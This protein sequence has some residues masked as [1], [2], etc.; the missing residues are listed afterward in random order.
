MTIGNWQ[1]ATRAG[2]TDWDA[3]YGITIDNAGNCY[4]TGYF[5]GTATFGFYSLT[6]SG[7]NDIF[8]AKLDAIGNWLWAARAGGNHWD[9]GKAISID[10]AGNSYVIGEFNGYSNIWFLLSYRQ[11]I[12][13]IYL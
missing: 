8:V 1:W 7:E 13:L 10:E 3:G 2:G 4:V 11:R 12:I 5:E 6:S 9:R